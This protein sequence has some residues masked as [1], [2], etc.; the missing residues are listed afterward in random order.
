LQLC[1]LPAMINHSS[2]SSIRWDLDE[3]PLD[4]LTVYEVEDE[5]FQVVHPEEWHLDEVAFTEAMDLQIPLWVDD[6]W[7]IGYGIR[8]LPPGV[9]VRDVL[10]TIFRFYKAEGTFRLRGWKNFQ[11][12][13]YDA[14]TRVAKVITL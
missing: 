10:Q 3:S 9:K 14:A 7:T 1:I 2:F 11:T 6:K 12:I 4:A 8:K 5:G 13:F